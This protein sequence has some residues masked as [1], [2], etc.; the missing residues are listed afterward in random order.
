MCCLVFDFDFWFNE[1]ITCSRYVKDKLIDFAYVR[2]IPS[3][4]DFDILS[5]PAKST[6]WIFE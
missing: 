4:W 3:A 6:K 5:E 2:T 1:T